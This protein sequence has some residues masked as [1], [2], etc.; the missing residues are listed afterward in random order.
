MTKHAL[1][2]QKRRGKRADRIENGRGPVDGHGRGA[3]ERGRVGTG[4]SAAAPDAGL[5]LSERAAAVRPLRTQQI[6]QR[7]LCILT[8]WPAPLPPHLASYCMEQA[9]KT[10][11][12]RAAA[13]ALL[14]SLTHVPPAYCTARPVCLL[15]RSDDDSEWYGTQTIVQYVTG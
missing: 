15:P 1:S 11:T 5:S 8:E 13:P 7:G 14:A 10:L 3:A 6:L 12:G 2:W 4:H 9:S